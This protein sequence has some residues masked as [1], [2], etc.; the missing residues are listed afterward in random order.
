MGLT[1]RA[2]S[3]EYHYSK[4]KE[5]V[6]GKEYGLSTDIGYI[7]FKLFRDAL[8]KFTTNGAYSDINKDK[9]FDG[10]YASDLVN[11]FIDDDSLQ[12][13]IDDEDFLSEDL[14]K[15]QDEVKQYKHK[16]FHMKEHYPKLYQVFPLIAHCDCDGEMPLK[17]CQMILPVIKEFYKQDTHNYGYS[18]WNYNFTEEFISILEEVISHRGKLYFS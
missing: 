7:G 6:V 5:D 15:Y 18:G 1:L 16:L 13:C 2:V 11:S 14:E 3:K 4:I 9:Y 12:V 8:V 17:Q 10:K